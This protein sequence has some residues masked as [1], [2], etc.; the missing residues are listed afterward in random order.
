MANESIRFDDGAGYELMMG[1]WSQLVGERFIDWIGVP[2]GLAGLTSA[3][4]TARLRNCWSSAAGLP[5]SRPSI[6][7]RDSLSM[8]AIAC[9][10]VRP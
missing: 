5:A 6:R 4:A 10:P 3:A 7:R 2:D 1:R 9:Q 8:P